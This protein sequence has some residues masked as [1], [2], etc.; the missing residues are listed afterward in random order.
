MNNYF[1]MVEAVSSIAAN[2]HTY[3][4]LLITLAVIYMV[5]IYNV[6]TRLRTVQVALLN[7]VYLLVYCLSWLGYVTARQTF[8]RAWLETEAFAKSEGLLFEHIVPVPNYFSVD[9][10]NFV[11]PYRNRLTK[12]TK[13]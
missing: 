1:E 3:F 10:S 7:A 13:S 9:F 6:G 2:L 12:S 8:T 11:G 4:Q 5:A